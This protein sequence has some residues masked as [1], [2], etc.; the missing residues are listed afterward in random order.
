MSIFI[1]IDIAEKRGCALAA[2]DASGRA[3]GSGWSEC[4]TRDVV[5]EVRRLAGSGPAPI[6]I[7][8]PRMPAREARAWYWEGGKGWRARRPAEKG[9]GRHCEVVISAMTLANPQWTPPG[10]AAPG[11]MRFG[12]SL[13]EAL[14]D[15][16]DVVEVFPSASY[17]MLN[18]FDTPRLDLPLRDFARGPKDMLDAYIGA[19]TAREFATGRGCEVGGGDGLGTIVLPCPLEKSPPA[20]L[21]W[22]GAVSSAS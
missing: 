1:G 18:A 14:R 20:L 17:T 19:L 10:D 22:P 16:G 6:G 7:D 11:W 12:F 2:L 4:N 9:W 8:A 15:C 5:T 3:V 21:S 13:F